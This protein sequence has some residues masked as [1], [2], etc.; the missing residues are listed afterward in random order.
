[1][2]SINSISQLCE[3]TGADIGE[4]AHAIGELVRRNHRRKEGLLEIVSSELR[5]NPS[6]KLGLDSRIGSKFLQS[7]VGFGGSCFGKDIKALVYLAR[8]FH[9][10]DVANYWNQVGHHVHFPY[11]V[12]LRICLAELLLALP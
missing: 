10:H 7:S 5:I 8:S 6:H 9:L 11:L 3:E 12:A 2:S 1:M 4:V